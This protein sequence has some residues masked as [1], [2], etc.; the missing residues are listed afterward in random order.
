MRKQ[1]KPKTL[2]AVID[3][4]YRARDSDKWLNLVNSLTPNERDA[5][6]RR[7]RERVE[8]DKAKFSPYLRRRQVKS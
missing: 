1:K 4:L 5:A 6:L 8:A 3:A 2:D 7:V